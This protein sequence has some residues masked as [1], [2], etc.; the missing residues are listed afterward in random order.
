MTRDRD[1]II[2]LVDE[3]GEEVE[4]EHID[5]I[6]MGDNEY[7]VLLPKDDFVC[8][9]DDCE[10]EDCEEEEVVILKVETNED[11]E[12][13]FVAIEDEDEQNAVFEI[14]TKRIEDSELY[15]FDDEDDID[16]TGGDD[17]FDGE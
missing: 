7:V 14:F 5:T 12:D 2:I 4:V 10:C 1:D 3:N 6:E 15:E 17:D 9:D 8:S 11:G 16:E 13:T